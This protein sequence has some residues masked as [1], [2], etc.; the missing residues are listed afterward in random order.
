MI[1]GLE[2]YKK[3]NWN[4]CKRY[5]IKFDY[6]SINEGDFIFINLDDFYQFTQLI[7]SQRFNKFNLITH[8][9]DLSFDDRML[10]NIKSHIDKIYSINCIVNDSK[11]VKIPLGFSDRLIPIISSMNVDNNKKYLLYM[12]FNIHS[13]RISERVECRNYFSKFDW[14]NFED[15]VPET[16]YYQNLMISKYSACPIGAGLDT[17]RF[18]ESIYLNTIPIV[19]RNEISDLHSK[20]P[21]IIVDSWNEITE[22]SLIRNYET[23]IKKLTDWKKNNDWLSPNFWLK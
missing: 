21:C 20:F 16:Q 7:K 2:F 19:K 23:N 13:G 18:Y 15:L 5:P 11:V 10:N 3:C 1:S 9:S 8:N 6:K 22:D 4:L 14:V 12:N 17:H